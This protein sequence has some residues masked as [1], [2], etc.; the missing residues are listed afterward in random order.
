MYIK[1]VRVTIFSLLA[2]FHKSKNKKEELPILLQTES[3]PTTT[4][5]ILLIKSTVSKESHNSMAK[6]NDNAHDFQK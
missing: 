4:T 1:K 5:K 2:I 6:N 3:P